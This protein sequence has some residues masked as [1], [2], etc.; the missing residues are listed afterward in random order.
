MKK[1]KLLLFRNY[2]KAKQRRKIGF[3]K[4]Y[5]KLAIFQFAHYL[6]VER[7]TFNVTLH[8][9]KAF[10]NFVCLKVLQFSAFYDFHLSKF[11]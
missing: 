1:L 11:S 10:G 2:N 4:F 5:D 9:I 8:G 3:I 6:A 7:N